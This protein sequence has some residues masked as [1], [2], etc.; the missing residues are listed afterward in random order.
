VKNLYLV[1]VS[2][3]YGP[4]SFLPVAISYQWM[5]ASTS[6]LVKENFQVADV[7]IEKK[8]PKKYVEDLVDEPHVIML[9]SYVWNWE[10][11][12]E[13]A[14]QIKN[15]YP[16]CL[17]ITGG[18]HVDKR[19]SE[20][21]EKYPMFDIAVMGEGEE[22]SREILRR[23]ILG[24]DYTDI[25]HVFPK[26]GKLCPLPT[27]LQELDRIPSP[28]LT[29]FYD[30]IIKDVEEEHGPQMWQVTYETLRGCPY[31][32]TFCDIGDDYWQKIKMFD[33]E[34]VKQEIDWM[35]DRKIEYVAVCDSNWGLMP[36]DVDITKY[37]I[38][39]KQETGYP[40]F[41]DV[42]WAKANSDR[43]YEI[44]MLDKEAGT[45]LFKGITFAMQS[46]NTDTLDATK[47]LNLKQDQ[48]LEYL[49]KYKEQDIPTYS[50]LIWPMPNET[51]DS[52]KSGIQTLIDLGQKDFLMVHP[53]V[54]TYNATMGQPWYQEKYK[55]KTNEVP[56]DT[57]YLSVEELEDY[58]VEKTYAV[59]ETESAPSDA[60]LRGHL[61]SH[62]IIVLYY[63]GWGHYLLE[64]LN[65]KYGY[66]HI[67]V[68][69]KMLDYFI[70]S[71]NLVGS[72]LRKT[73]NSLIDVFENGKFW[74]R[75]VLGDDDIF[76]EYKGATSIIFS[77]NR[78]T[79]KWELIEF[80]KEEYNL[81]IE[82]VVSFNMDM[83]R[84]YEYSY[85]IKK[86]YLEDTIKYCTGL[87][88]TTIN[89]T[90]WDSEELTPLEFYHRAYHYQRKNRYWRN[91]I[92][93]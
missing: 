79:L 77:K 45:R 60:V 75:Q 85:P 56:L 42:T 27:R 74:G 84:D 54:I 70:N 16:K 89:I 32:C 59:V 18:P 55:F 71:D 65:N 1:Q 15:K 11:N 34:R 67:D 8:P 66:K 40:K 21:F 46:L 36:R 7:L 20:F 6:K 37:V 93:I 83:C 3:K 88:S 91:S 43:I 81:D 38:Q 76:W 58:I 26:G 23:Y 78:E 13:L 57:F 41:W 64:Y 28:I 82:D 92:F 22:A 73:N 33:M 17:T 10:Y 31:K 12:K 51:Y 69:E 14:K 9:S 4:N 24:E 53:L 80:C 50:E 35:S 29:G 90:H 39:K 68:A 86:Q 49:Q 61:L 5:Y 30:R 72:E 19:D 87:D 52:L 2:D 48:A 62:L 47:R 25:P 44:A 63:Y